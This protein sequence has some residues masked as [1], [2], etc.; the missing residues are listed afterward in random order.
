MP[1]AFWVARNTKTE[2]IIHSSCFFKYYLY[3]NDPPIFISSP[4]FSLKFQQPPWYCTW[5]FNGCSS[6][7]Y[8]LNFCLLPKKLS[9]LCQWNSAIPITQLLPL[10][11]PLMF[12][13]LA[14]SLGFLFKIYWE[15]EHLSPPSL[16]P[17]GPNCYYFSPGSLYLS[18]KGS[19]CP[20]APNNPLKL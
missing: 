19:P 18:A 3:A 7:V 6:S 5:M 9:H 11:P 2:K 12:N 17:L 10:F 4:D 16:L 15:S 20:P 14:E 8:W 1:A 13:L